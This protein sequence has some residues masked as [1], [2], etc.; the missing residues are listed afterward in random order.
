MIVRDAAK[1]GVSFKSR[2]ESFFADFNLYTHMAHFVGKQLHLRPNDILD[3]WGVPE[4]IVA[5]GQYM[6]ELANENYQAWKSAHRPKGYEPPEPQRY[7]VRFIGP[8]MLNEP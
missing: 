7:V 2:R 6:N 5:Y 1:S 3:K 8:K 4:L